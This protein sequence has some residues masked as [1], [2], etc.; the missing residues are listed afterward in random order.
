MIRPYSPGNFKINNVSYPGAFTG[1]PTLSWSHRDRTQQTQSIIEHDAGNIG[2]EA[3]VT[4]TLKI[5]DAGNT[6]RRT[7]TGL[8]GTSYTY[9]QAD[10]ISDCGS[11]Q[12]KLRFVL[13]AV[14]DGYD[15][16]Q[17]YDITIPRKV[18]PAAASAISSSANPT[19]V[20]S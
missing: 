6:L 8:T 2:P 16:W 19:V 14:R 9:T 3:G 5:Y 13:T 7:E 17:S 1:E 15:S 20:I 11:V 12:T 18:A 4:Y 10:E